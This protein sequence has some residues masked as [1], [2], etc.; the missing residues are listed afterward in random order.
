MT[1]PSSMTVAFRADASLDIGTG[2]VMRCLTLA[3]A[4]REQGAKCHFICREHMG[5]L[6]DLI[7]QRGFSANVLPLCEDEHSP[8]QDDKTTHSAH[9]NWLACDWRTDASQTGEILNKI[10]P[11][12]LVVDHYALDRRW[13]EE[14]K[15]LYGKLMVIDDLA[16]RAHRCNLLMDQNLG[17]QRSDYADLVQKECVVLAGP[18][19]ALLRP[20]FANLRAYS[21][22]RRETPVLKQILITMGGIDLP[23]ATGKVLEAL[24]ASPLPKECRIIVVMGSH[25]PWLSQVHDMAL[26]M[27]WKTD[28]R[29][30][31]KDMAQVMAVSD[32]AIGAAGSTS[33]ERGC[34]G[35]P[36]LMVVLAMNQQTIADALI[37]SG[38]AVSPGSITDKDFSQKFCKMFER[39]I[40]QPGFLEAMSTKAADMTDGHG[41]E[42]LTSYM[43]N[44]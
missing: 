33:W 18:Q 10:K 21:L 38:A 24:K 32:L 16:D 43:W 8:A 13:E 39:L 29:V 35:L 14:L 25:A 9:A 15:G 11:D 42:K 22:K 37:D 41:A 19:Y 28:V 36:T 7:R 12:W 23:N 2:H 17:R 5:S 30:D 27:P 26:T 3:D 34:L 44:Q 4:L 31:I 40:T 20:D 1:H 6:N